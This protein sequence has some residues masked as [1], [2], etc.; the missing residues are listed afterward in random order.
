MS[1]CAAEMTESAGV[2]ILGLMEGGSKCCVGSGAN[3]SLNL[4]PVS[5][6]INTA[7]D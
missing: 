2:F 5:A 6:S 4:Q 3:L 7:I 1:T